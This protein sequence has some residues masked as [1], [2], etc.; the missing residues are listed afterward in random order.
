MTERYKKMTFIIYY[1]GLRQMK[2]ACM[3]LL[4]S[5]GIKAQTRQNARIVGS[6]AR[7]GD[8]PLVSII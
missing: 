7:T 3:Y 5:V 4:G 1:I 6:A 8:T 2:K